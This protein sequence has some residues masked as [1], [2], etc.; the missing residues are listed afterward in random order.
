MKTLGTLLI[1]LLFLSGCSQVTPGIHLYQNTLKANQ[2]SATLP[3]IQI[4]RTYHSGTIKITRTL[5]ASDLGNVLVHEKGSL[6]DGYEFVV[7]NVSLMYAGFEFKKYKVRDAG[8]YH[9]YIEGIDRFGNPV[10][11]LVGTL[12][13]N[14]ELFY[15]NTPKLIE[16]LIHCVQKRRTHGTL[17]E[18][19]RK[20]LSTFTCTRCHRD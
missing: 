10:Y 11:V 5:Y 12:D 8:R 15:A 2:C 14:F 19:L 13:Q 4:E 6:D 20:K 16:S 7:G 1:I 17:Y 3:I 9:D 18:T